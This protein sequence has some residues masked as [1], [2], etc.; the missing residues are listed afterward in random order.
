[1]RTGFY[2]LAVIA[3]LLFA[4]CIVAP[5]TAMS[6]TP[7]WKVSLP[8]EMPVIGITIA[9][10]GSRVLVRGNNLMMLSN[11]GKLLWSG[12]AGGIAAMS[13]N[14]AYVVLAFGESLRLLDSNGVEIWTR[15]GG[16]PINAVAITPNGSLVISDNTRGYLMTWNRAGD[17]LGRVQLDPA[18]SIAVSP[19]G[20]LIVIASDAGLRYVNA[21]MDLLWTDNSSGNFETMIALSSDGSIIYTAGGNRV[22]SHTSTGTLNW[23]KDVTSEQ[24]TGM[25]CSASGDVLVLGSQDKNVYVLDSN[26]YTRLK[27]PIGQWINA[28]SVSRDGTLIAAGDINRYLTLFFRNGILAGKVRTD[29]IIQPY[30]VALSP[31]GNRVVVGD[32][33]TIYG[34]TL[35]P[36]IMNADETATPRPM[37]SQTSLATPVSQITTDLPVPVGSGTGNLPGAAAT[38]KQSSPSLVAG[39]CACAIVMILFRRTV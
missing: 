4:G 10:D 36:D 1:M 32:E 6:I 31:D 13:G 16:A 34:Y 5:V 20:D 27:Y 3:M 19:A 22:S 24:I 12:D 39:V 14:G 11:D 30:S 15:N 26:G 29:R 38:T 2:M 8:D 9:D 23:Q 25:A 7:A 17:S 33:L 37:V 28:V 35:G 18:K 21:G